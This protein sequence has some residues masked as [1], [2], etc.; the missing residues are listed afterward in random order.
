[1]GQTAERRVFD[2]VTGFYS[3]RSLN[4]NRECIKHLDH[5]NFRGKK[6]RRKCSEQVKATTANGESKKKNPRKEYSS[7]GTGHCIHI[8]CTQRSIK[9]NETAHAIFTL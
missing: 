9:E 3:H 2:F 4:E 5:V 8:E 1:M 7:T 6:D